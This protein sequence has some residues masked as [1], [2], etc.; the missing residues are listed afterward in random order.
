M[1][2]VLG[3]FAGLVASMGTSEVV[4]NII[5]FLFIMIYMI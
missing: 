1:G 2:N 3:Q 4:T 5:K